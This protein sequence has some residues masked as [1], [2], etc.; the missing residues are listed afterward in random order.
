MRRSVEAVCPTELLETL[1]RLFPSP[2]K[3]LRRFLRDGVTWPGKAAGKSRARAKG[4]DL[5]SFKKREREREAY[6]CGE[7]FEKQIAAACVGFL[8][9]LQGLFRGVGDDVARRRHGQQMAPRALCPREE[10]LGPRDSACR[11]VSSW[12]LLGRGRVTCSMPPCAADGERTQTRGSWNAGR[13]PTPAELQQAV[14]SPESR[15]SL[16]PLVGSFFVGAPSARPAAFSGIF[17]SQVAKA[18][19]PDG[20]ERSPWSPGE[21]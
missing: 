3:E 15:G 17:R 5:G 9:K 7:V 8:G 10:R 21:C 16:L 13:M 4:F 19:R 20:K 1:R 11:S 2:S 18:I 14:R 6:S 12:K